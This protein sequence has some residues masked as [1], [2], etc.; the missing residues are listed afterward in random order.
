MSEKLDGWN[1]KEIYIKKMKEINIIFKQNHS[2]ELR[3]IYYF[4]ENI[5]TVVFAYSILKICLYRNP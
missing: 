1:M 3:R 2:L 5:F 4:W